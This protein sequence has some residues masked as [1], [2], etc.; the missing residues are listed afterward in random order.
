LP[1]WDIGV[2]QSFRLTMSSISIS[3]ADKPSG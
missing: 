2:A 1:E 3:L